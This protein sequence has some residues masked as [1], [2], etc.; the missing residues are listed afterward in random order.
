MPSGRECLPVY[1][2]SLTIQRGP[3]CIRRRGQESSLGCDDYSML[4]RSVCVFPWLLWFDVVHCDGNIGAL[5]I[6]PC[7]CAP[8]DRD[9]PGRPGVSS[10][11]LPDMG[12]NGR[13]DNEPIIVR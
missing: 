3:G 8:A 10:D 6:A 2:Q 9:G 12:V 4:S 5:I 11:H 13:G 7:Q 1:H